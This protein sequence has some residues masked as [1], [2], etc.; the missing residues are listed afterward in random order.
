MPQ[1]KYTMLCKIQKHESTSNLISYGKYNI[2]LR[3][4]SFL[5]KAFGDF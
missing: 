5:N 2:T 1:R 4:A 3:T